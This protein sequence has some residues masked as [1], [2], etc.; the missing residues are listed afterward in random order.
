MNN[1][2]YTAGLF[3]GEGTVTLSHGHRDDKY[4]NPMATMSSTTYELM[5]FLKKN[6]GGSIRKHK[7][8]KDHHKKAYSWGVTWNKAL[9]FLENIQPYIKVPKKK[10]RINHILKEYKKVTKRNGQYTE[11]ESALKLEFERRFF[12]L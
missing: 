9:T 3:D 2:I 4:R 11:K 12:E 10:R 6:Y 1:I 5:E 7:V 8:Y